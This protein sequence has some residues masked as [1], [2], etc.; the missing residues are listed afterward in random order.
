[1]LLESHCNQ[2]NAKMQPEAAQMQLRMTIGT[3]FAQAD[4][5]PCCLGVMTGTEAVDKM[6]VEQATSQVQAFYVEMGN[7]AAPALREFCE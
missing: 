3:N 5:Q 1:M 2:L 7:W 4:K 6:I